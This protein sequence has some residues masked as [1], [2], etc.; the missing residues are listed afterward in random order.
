MGMSLCWFWGGK[1]Q[2]QILGNTNQREFT[3]RISGI[4]TLQEVQE[5]RKD[6]NQGS[7]RLRQW[8][9]QQ[10]SQYQWSHQ[11]TSLLRWSRSEPLAAWLF[12]FQKGATNCLCSGLI[13]AHMTRDWWLPHCS[14]SRSHQRGGDI[15][16]LW[17]NGK[18]PEQSR[19]NQSSLM[20]SGKLNI[21]IYETHLR[22][23]LCLNGIPKR[24]KGYTIYKYMQ[25]L[26]KP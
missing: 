4:Q 2:K 22:M 13:L 7:S 3:E 20:I 12:T 24:L 16:V 8:E 14:P 6:R 1:Q 5:P 18:G 19:N 21:S 10:F 26:W 25:V 15:S 9:V 23:S 11:D 17:G